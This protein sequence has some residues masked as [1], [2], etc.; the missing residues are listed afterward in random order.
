METT[1]LQAK[2][3]MSYYC[4][5]KLSTK[6]LSMA[7]VLCRALVPAVDQVNVYIACNQLGLYDI[8]DCIH[9]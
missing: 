6:L 1:T 9:K 7:S 3:R 5:T 4:Y 8:S 2:V